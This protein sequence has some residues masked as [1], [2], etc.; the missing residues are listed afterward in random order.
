MRI[1][2]AGATGTVGRYVRDA[3]LARGHEVTAL[4]RST[5]QD[6]LTGSGLAEAVVGADA[7]V[8]VTSVVTVSAR[9]S[10]G[11]F[12]TATRN[13]LAAE[14]AGGVGHHLALSIVGIDDID[15]GYYAGKLAQEHAVAAGPVPWSIMRATQFHE[16]VSQVLAQATVGPL[17]FVPKFLMRPV[18]AR[19]VADRLIDVVEAGPGGRVKDLRG[20]ADERL[21]TLVRR[22]F[23]FDGT[24]RRAVEFS[25]PG[26]FARGAASGVLRG[27]AD[28][29]SGRVSFDQWLRSPD[30][31]TR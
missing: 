27:S 6:V 20:P 15:S 18:A 1:I 17:A 5:G 22:M 21:I 25:S 24:K 26:G 19:E 10:R 11:F 23:E 30:H 14:S 2:V 9:K 8:D 7:V 16:F 13:L 31:L 29:Q 3:A 12:T 4:S 28:A